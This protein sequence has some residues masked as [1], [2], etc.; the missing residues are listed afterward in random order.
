M[1]NEGISTSGDILDLAVADEIV[2]K[3]GAWFSYGEIRLG[4]GREN[5]KQYFRDNPELLNEIR[6]RILADRGMT[7]DGQAKPEPVKSNDEEVADQVAPV[8]EV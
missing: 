8:V 3:S 6:E 4:Q 1:F 5:S 2:K 7:P